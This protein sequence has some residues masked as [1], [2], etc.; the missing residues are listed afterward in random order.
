MSSTRYTLSAP[1]L[2]ST[3]VLLSGK[4]LALGRDGAIPPLTGMPAP[5]GRMKFA[6]TTNSFVAF[7]DAHDPECH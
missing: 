2:E 3:T 4:T 5:A 7:A 1:R 6:P